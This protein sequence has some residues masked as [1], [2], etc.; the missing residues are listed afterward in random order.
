MTDT[1]NFL[2]RLLREQAA[3]E[4]NR[5][6]DHALSGE[7]IP[8]LDMWPDC[9]ICGGQIHHDGDVFY[10]EG[11]KVTWPTSGMGGTKEDE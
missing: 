2:E 1:D 6:K 11:C 4:L 9:S 5:R 10:C 3:R 7:P 8:D